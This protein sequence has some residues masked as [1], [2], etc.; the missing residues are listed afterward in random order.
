MYT[1]GHMA[2]GAHNLHYVPYFPPVMGWHVFSP[3]HSFQIPPSEPES[4]VWESDLSDESK[5]TLTEITTRPI[6]SDSFDLGSLD[7]HA[8]EDTIPKPKGLLGKPSGGGYYS[9]S[10]AL[11]WM[12]VD[13]KAVQACISLFFYITLV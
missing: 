9:L 4:S 8:Y 11:G 3:E 7:H 12:S 1:F 10:K 6:T 13:Y 5:E 2:P